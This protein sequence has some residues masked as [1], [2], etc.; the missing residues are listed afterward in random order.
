MD[1]PP[2][3]ETPLPRRAKDASGIL[4][5]RTRFM[6]KRRSGRKLPR[7]GAATLL[8][9]FILVALVG[10]VATMHRKV[11][12]RDFESRVTF[13]RTAPDEVKRIRHDLADLELSQK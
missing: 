4:A 1:T 13:S 7:P 5:V 2:G 12:E 3:A 6:R 8:F 11:L 10:A 9:L